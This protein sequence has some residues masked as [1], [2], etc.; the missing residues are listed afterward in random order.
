MW[1]SRLFEADALAALDGVGDPRLVLEAAS[2]A[3][4]AAADHFLVDLDHAEPGGAGERI[5]AHGLPD[6]VA[7]VPGRLVGRAQHP[8]ELVGAHPL[9]RLA[10][11]YT[12]RN[13]FRSGRWLRCMM[14]PA[15][16]ENWWLQERHIQSP[17]RRRT[18]STAMSSQRRHT[19]PAGHRK[20]RATRYN[21][22]HC[23]TGRSA[24]TGCYSPRLPGWSAQ[25]WPPGRSRA[26]PGPPG[27]SVRC[28]GSHARSKKRSI[29]PTTR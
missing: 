12:A 28:P 5:V 29:V 24:N 19:G 11:R 18:G 26:H 2:A 8:V 15:V 27:V 1:G 4:A 16:T 7:K 23:R 6:P 25:R 20:D 17:R 22:R 3:P 9:L 13:H 10:E 21:C 14:A